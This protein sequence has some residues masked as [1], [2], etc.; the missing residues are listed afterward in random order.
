MKK[1]KQK[2]NHMDGGASAPPILSPTSMRVRMRRKTIT[3][4]GAVGIGQ[5][6]TVPVATARAWIA[7]GMAMEDKTV[8]VPETKGGA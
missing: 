4:W 2:H 7:K 3:A 5:V 6:L 8:D 1:D